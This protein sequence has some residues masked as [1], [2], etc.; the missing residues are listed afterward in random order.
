MSAA[1]GRARVAQAFADLLDAEGA[2]KIAEEIGSDRST[3]R[4]RGSD[5]AAWSAA[6]LITLA[7]AHP[8]VGDAV[9]S[10]IQGDVASGQAQDVERE[11]RAIARESA[12]EIA[13]LLTRLEDGH[14]DRGEAR[15]TEAELAALEQ[16]IGK[17]RAE[18]RARLKQGVRA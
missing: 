8:C 2:T 14:I 12:A 5:L 13:A 15:E 18:I 9:V 1:A 11:L 7:I 4:R 16:H 10:A 17:A 6:D 3:P